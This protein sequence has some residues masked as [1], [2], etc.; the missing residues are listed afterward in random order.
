MK[1]GN[2]NSKLDVYVCKDTKYK[3]NHNLIHDFLDANER[4]EFLKYYAKKTVKYCPFF[5]KYKFLKT[6]ADI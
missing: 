5:T 1:K 4:S 3:V 6:G 2:R